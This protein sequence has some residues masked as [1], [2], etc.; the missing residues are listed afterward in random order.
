MAL[1]QSDLDF[2]LFREGIGDR[3]DHHLGA[4]R[5]VGQLHGSPVAVRWL[6]AFEAAIGQDGVAVHRDTLAV[7]P[8]AGELARKHAAIL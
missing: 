3:A 7:A 5:N 6:I 4:E 2:R 8:I 1:A